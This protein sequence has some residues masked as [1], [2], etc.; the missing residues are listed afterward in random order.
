MLIVFLFSLYAS[1]EK[2]D[3][4]SSSRSDSDKNKRQNIEKKDSSMDIYKKKRE[5][6]VEKQIV[7]RGV[8]NKRVIDAMLAVSR[9][10]FVPE[11]MK[12]YAYYDR[13]LPIDSEQTISQ[14]YIVALMTELVSPSPE[15]KVL[16]IGTG[17]GYQAAVLAEITDTVYTIEII[18]NLVDIASENI[19]NAGYENIKIRHGDGYK[20]WPSEAPFDSIMITAATKKIPEPLIKQL[21]EGG[22]IVMP[23]GQP[24]G[25]QEL[26]VGVKKGDKLETETVTA[27]RFVPMTGDALED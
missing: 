16:E 13:P 17:S 12:P 9:E 27:V 15:D 10:N 20:G 21:K 26:I 18:K 3:S 7:G 25:M 4:P 2:E 6:M 24:G 8:K 23:L 11:K 14:P 22:K 1:S 5:T 19:K